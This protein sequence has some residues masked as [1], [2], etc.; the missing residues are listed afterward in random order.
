MTTKER[1]IKMMRNDNVNI[2][3]N[4][5]DT[6][7]KAYQAFEKSINFNIYN[8]NI[9]AASVFTYPKECN[10]RYKLVVYFHSMSQNFTIPF[11]NEEKL[12]FVLMYLVYAFSYIDMKYDSSKI[13]MNNDMVI[14]L[15]PLQN[16]EEEYVLDIMKNLIKPIFL[17]RC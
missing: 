14:R 15:L 9:M 4:K 10:I 2:I 7:N 16:E 8:H 11:L 17:K 5:Q 12:Y 3:T 6:S 1:F 13:S